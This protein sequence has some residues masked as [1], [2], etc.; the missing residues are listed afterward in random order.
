MGRNLLAIL[1]FIGEK[2]N[3]YDFSEGKCE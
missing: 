2:G 3:F 1:S